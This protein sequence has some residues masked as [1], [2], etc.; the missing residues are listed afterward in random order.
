MANS[1]IVDEIKSRVVKDIINSPAIVAAIDATDIDYPDDLD[2]THIFRFAQ[3]PNVIQNSGTFLTIQV[4]I[5]NYFDKNMI[6]MR[7]LLEIWIVSNIKHMKVTNISG[8]TANRNDYLSQ[9]IDE[10]FNGREDFG[11]GMLKLEKNIEGAHSDNHD[12]SYRQM[13]FSTRDLSRTSC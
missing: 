13:L 8:V 10:K 7:H 1:S 3:N 12:F 9:L 5:P 11:F 6:W 4:H 2:N